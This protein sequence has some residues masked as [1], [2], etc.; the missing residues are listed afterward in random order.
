MN[1]TR[2][3]V[4]AAVLAT[5]FLA[6]LL[7][8]RPPGLAEVP[9]AL[10]PVTPSAPGS[11]QSRAAGPPTPPP[12]A[13][14]FH[15]SLVESA[16]YQTYIANLRSIGCPEQTVRDI[17]VADVSKLFAPRYAALSAGAPELAWWGRYDARKPVRAELTT[18]LRAL[19]DEKKALLL[20]LLGAQAAADISVAD[21]TVAGVREQTALAFLPEPKQS[22]LRD[23]LSRYQALHDW[24]ET[25]WKGLPSDE[26]D[27]KEK[28]FRAVRTRELALLLTPEELRE[29]ELRDSSTASAVR[30][31]LGRA[32]L[33]EEEFRQ[34]YDLRRDFEQRLPVAHREDWKRFDADLAAALGPERFADIQR[35]NNSMWI[36]LQGIA[37][38]RNLTP[39]AMLGAY[40]IQR[41]YA[42]KMAQAVGR[43]FA[44]PQQNPQPLRDLAAQM[45]SQL[46][47][48]I[49]PEVVKHLDRLGVLPRLVIQDDGKR[50]IYSF[51]RGALGE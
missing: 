14:P 10:L 40:G 51:S 27:A 41:D 37:N 6:G 26:R 22:A 30:E 45:D 36:A 8:R 49:G 32:N 5:G 18:Q 25:Q 39:D 34:L 46:A 9:T 44:D 23:L 16:D 12:L 43:M 28:E 47:G 3:L 11:S 20:R 21:A 33:T 48:V 38:E 24:S 2:I 35:Q 4:L 13:K 17:I 19:D 7:C 15:W 31:Q 29:F 50:K 42:D 1:L